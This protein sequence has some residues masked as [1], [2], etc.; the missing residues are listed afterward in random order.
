MSNVFRAWVAG[1]A[2]SFQAL[3]QAAGGVLRANRYNYTAKH[4]P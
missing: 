3:T 4:G 1:P 2:H